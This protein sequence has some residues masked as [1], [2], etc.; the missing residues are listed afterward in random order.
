MLLPL[1]VLDGFLFFDR[2]SVINRVVVIAFP[3]VVGYFGLGCGF[4]LCCG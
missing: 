3:H 4:F 1:L 2:T